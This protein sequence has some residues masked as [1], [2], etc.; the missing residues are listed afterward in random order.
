VNVRRIIVSLYLVL[1]V[2]IIVMSAAFF[3]QTRAEYRQ[4]Q[5]VEAKNQK[6]LAEMEQRLKE[7]QV[8]LDRLRNDPVFVERL[9]RKKLLYVKPDERIFRFRE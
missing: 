5:E 7:Q 6:K 1:F 4:L 3:V 2:G 9:I 8:V